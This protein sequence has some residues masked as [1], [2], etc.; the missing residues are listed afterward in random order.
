[1]ATLNVTN[2]LSY[3]LP[4]YSVTTFVLNGGVSAGAPGADAGRLR[5]AGA[6]WE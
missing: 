1:M 5:R 6:D 3:T 4:P 2:S